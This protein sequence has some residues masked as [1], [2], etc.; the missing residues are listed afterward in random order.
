MKEPLRRKL[1]I[2]FVLLSMAAL[3]LLQGGIVAVSIRSSY[4]ELVQKSDALLE[5]VRQNAAT[6]VRH[7]SVKVTSDGV[8][9]PDAVH[10]VALSR[11]EMVSLAETA[12]QK[13]TERGFAKEYRY[14]VYSAEKGRRI[15]FLP[16][17]ASLEAHRESSVN[18]VQYS[19]AGLGAMCLLL[20]FVSDW[21]VAPLV[22]NRRRQKQF[23]TAAGHELKTPLTVISTDA[24]LLQA[25]IGENPWLSGILQQVDHLTRMTGDL[26]MLAKA[27][28]YENPVCREKFSLSAEV[29]DVLAAYE[30]LEKQKGLRLVSSVQELDYC[31]VRQEI[32]RLLC[33]LLDNAFKYCSEGGEISVSLRGDD[34]TVRLTV[35]NPAP[36][37]GDEK[38]LTRRFYRGEN[39][40]G[41][42]GFGLG[43]SIA[44][45]IARRHKGT[46]TVKRPGEDLFLAEVT[47][48]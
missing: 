39:T 6:N 46:I 3:L 10:Y 42:E 34:R 14:H 40:A 11:E 25:E 17:G 37:Q 24:Q 36:W 5:Q 7:F 15:L 33:V 32:H 2:R 9:R 48:R 13:Q 28:E 38:L 16:R 21:V 19:A 4:R 27:E 26:V 12:L 23:I 20:V 44:Q 45:A 43:L 31:G 47:L 18:L 41:T 8:I 29:R 30:G 1:R 22:E 35:S